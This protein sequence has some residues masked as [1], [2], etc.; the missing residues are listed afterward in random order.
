METL[1]KQSGPEVSAIVEAAKLHKYL[2]IGY[3]LFLFITVIFTVLVWIAS[4]RY[5]NPVKRDADSKIADA[6]A[7]AETAKNDAAK[8]DEKA[9]DA[10]TKQKEIEQQNLT[11]RGEVAKLQKEAADSQRAFLAL[12]EE[13]KPRELTTTQK[14]N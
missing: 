7:I 14:N 11:L 13:I 1:P 5:Q 12:Q 8:A 10:R 6:N 4:D 3:I 2:F 9:E